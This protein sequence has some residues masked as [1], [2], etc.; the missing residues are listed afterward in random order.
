M[1]MQLA[2]FAHEDPKGS[3]YYVQVYRWCRA[4]FSTTYTTKPG[5][6][7]NYATIILGVPGS[8]GLQSS[9][10]MTSHNN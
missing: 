10:N 7:T 6:G 5:I 2:I 1:A 8:K 3:F 4:P 9:T